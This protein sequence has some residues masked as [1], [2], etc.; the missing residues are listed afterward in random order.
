[1]I[2]FS[3]GVIYSNKPLSYIYQDTI[4]DLLHYSIPSILNWSVTGAVLLT[5]RFYWVVWISELILSAKFKE[6]KE[7]Q[8]E[9]NMFIPIILGKKRN[10]KIYKV[11]SGKDIR[12]AANARKKY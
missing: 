12:K 5:I 10:K 11:P 8:G 7:Y 3:W 2:I 6:Y 9:T 4:N 1:M